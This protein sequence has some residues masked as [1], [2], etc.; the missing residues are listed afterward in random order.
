[1]STNSEINSSRAYRTKLNSYDLLTF[2]QERELLKRAQAGD[3]E[4]RN[5]L[6]MHNMRLVKSI[7]GHY[8]CA[9]LDSDDLISIGSMGLVPAIEKFDLTS[10]HKFSTYATYWIKQ[11][12]RREIIN[13]NRT[14]RI[15]ANV[16]ETYN[17]IRKTT[18]TL[19]Q[20]LGHE[21][22]KRQ[23]AK[24][25][26]MTAKE[27]EEITS[28]FL[29]PIS[30]EVPLTD[31]DETTIGDLIADENNADPVDA[32][33]FNELHEAVSAI[34]ETLPEKEREVIRLRFGL[35]GSQQRS[36]EDVGELLGYSREWIRKIEA[37][38]LSKLR[39]PV[40]SNKLKS[41]LE[42]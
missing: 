39:N 29:E 30:T 15:P 28:F 9:G 8:T 5:E 4:A 42:V 23:V 7:A 1:M 41:F 32:V 26:G 16:Q 6:I 14:V 35:D 37:R 21:P 19:R 11:A 2:E 24:A 3:I 20:A 33:Y 40:R 31:E 18:E 13:Q 34:L 22:T 12:I 17:N 10:T 27:V 36:L 25:I 38:A